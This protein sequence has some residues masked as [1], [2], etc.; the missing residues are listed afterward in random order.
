MYKNL[1]PSVKTL[2]KTKPKIMRPDFFPQTASSQS[3]S[4][5]SPHLID[6]N[7]VAPMRPEVAPLNRKPLQKLAFPVLPMMIISKDEE[8]DSLFRQKC[9]LCHQICDFSAQREMQYIMAKEDILREILKY[10][11]DENC[12]LSDSKENYD[13]VFLLITRHIYR[14]PTRLPDE[15][16]SVSDYYYLTD[17]IIEPN[18]PH[19]SI[20]YDIMI[21]FIERPSFSEELATFLGGDLMKLCVYLFRSP[22]QREQQKLALLFLTLYHKM[23]GLRSFGLDTLQHSLR[24]IIYEDEPFTSAKPILS[25]LSNIIAGIKKPIKDRYLD[26]FYE[27]ILPLHR[28]LY[29]TYFHEQLETCLTQFLEKDHHLVVDLFSTL[30]KYWPRLQPYKQSIFLDEITYYSSF[31]ED[32]FLKETIPIILPQLMFSLDGVHAGI[33]EKILLMFEVN[34]FVWLMT[35]HPE[36][37]YPM[38]VSQLFITCRTYWNPDLRVISSAVLTILR[39]NNLLVFDQV[40]KNLANLE[41]SKIM[42]GFDRAGKWKYLITTYERS[43]KR[44]KY[45]LQW[46]SRLFVGCEPIIKK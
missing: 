12:K 2:A 22:D 18:W 32:D 42:V 30:I 5:H 11:Q 10:I 45:K 28:S 33:S 21:S 20:V 7:R 16:Y 34:D 24:R 15:W 27:S 38:L 19:N 26:L 13:A 29:F 35:I 44:R 25:A 41:S 4:I 23:R 14:T 43:S 40:G 9:A 36:L 6:S 17:Q 1:K 39:M 37:T 46:L 31:V 3:H 8:I